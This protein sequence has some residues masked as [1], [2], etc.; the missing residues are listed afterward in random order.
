MW[1]GYGGMGMWVGIWLGMWVGDVVWDVG[2]GCGLGVPCL[3]YSGKLVPS[4]RL[5]TIT[6]TQVGSLCM[7]VNTSSKPQSATATVQCHHSSTQ[8]I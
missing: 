8:G 5:H 2:W 3:A 6:A 4:K 7:P 1:V